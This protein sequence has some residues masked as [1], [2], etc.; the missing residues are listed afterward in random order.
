[1]NNEE[2]LIDVDTLQRMMDGSENVFVLDIRPRSQ[3][4]EWKIPGSH[5]LDA[6]QRTRDGDYS[7]FDQISFPENSRVVVVCAA[8]RTSQIAAKELRAKGIDAW[9]LIGGMKSWSLAWNLSRMK[10]RNFDLLQVRRT[11]KGCLSYIIYSNKEA[12]IIDASLPVKIYKELVEQFNLS[13]KYILETHI[14]A[15]HLSRSKE[16]A[17]LFNAPLFLPVPNKVHFPFQPV[18]GDSSFILGDIELKTI[19]TPGHTIESVCYYVEGK[20]IFTGDTLFTNG[21]GRPDLKSNDKET[22]E[23]SNLLYH[24]IEKIVSFPDRVLIL[25]A[26]TN[27]PVDFDGT[28]ISASIDE[29]KKNIPLL[30][31]RESEFVD[32]LIRNIPLPPPNYLTIVEKNLSGEYETADAAEL[33]AGANRCA[34][35]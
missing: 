10:F 35:S 26:H 34:I 3:R 12:A 2:H 31:R 32:M 30:K 29:V 7:V 19:S 33:E 17:D 27:K 9:S 20:I 21:V 15:D 5:Y 18:T 11:G 1:M 25:P 16:L 24:S 23:K 4:E 8:G 22:H 14:H 6:Y 13:V 28:L